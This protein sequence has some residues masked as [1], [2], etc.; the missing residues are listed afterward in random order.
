[1]VWSHAMITF[2]LDLDVVKPWVP[3]GWEQLYPR[4]PLDT[5]RNWPGGDWYLPDVRSAKAAGVDGFAVDVFTNGNA[6]NG[7]LTAADKLGGFQIAPCLDL[8]GGGTEASNEAAAIKAVG[9]YCD[10]AAKHPSAAKIGDAYVVFTYGTNQMP[11]E[12]WQRVRDALRK[13]GHQTWWMPDLN[14]SETTRYFPVFEGGY[15]FGGPGDWNR[16]VALFKASGKAFAG[17]MMPGYS[18]VG[19][20]YGDA[21]ATANYRGLWHDLM[22]SGTPWAMVVTWNDLSENTEIMP[23]SDWNLTRADLTRWEA[24]QWKGQAPPWDE[25]RLYL[26][27]PQ[28]VYPGAG[29]PVEALVLNGSPR[30]VRVSVELLD[31][32]RKPLG[33]GTNAVVAARADG[34]ATMTLKVSQVPTR[35]FLRARATLRAGGQVLASVL[36]APILIPDPEAQPGL[37][38]LY[39]SLPARQSLP[40]TV[41]ITLNGSPL[42]GKT[43]EARVVA[44]LGVTPQFSEVLFNGEVLK[45][46]LTAPPVPLTVPVRVDRATVTPDGANVIPVG[47]IKG[48]TEWGFYEARVTDQNYR[49]GYSDPIYLAPA[50]DLS[51]K[52]RYDFDEGNGTIASDAS[53]FRRTAEL[54]NVRWVSPGFGGQGACLGFN[55]KDARVSLAQGGTP[56]GPFSL[57]IAVR[58]RTYAGLIYCDDGGLW[59]GFTPDGKALYT[60]LRPGGGWNTAYGKTTIPLNQWTPLEFTWDGHVSRVFVN[61]LLDGEGDAPPAFGSGRCALGYNPFGHGSSYY[62]GD[63]DSLEI[64]TLPR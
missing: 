54:Q 16:A 59:M 24:A 42:G 3:E 25:P 6:A 49:V 23:N 22:D 36:S 12:A 31:A 14:V 45:N 19:G 37:R 43:A 56:N 7:Y 46:F 2:P 62:D 32:D 13:Q 20:G 48:G 61:G 30:P 50:G 41:K 64:K 27:T 52:A 51:L 29:A 5:R 63:L 33:V 9:D 57:K 44:P 40:G 60:R 4:Y 11:P 58:P 55:G 38:T 35:R 17:G 18:R 34:A 10:S 53:V 39:Y 8:G 28:A 21:G 47:A 15:Q 26:T 1:M